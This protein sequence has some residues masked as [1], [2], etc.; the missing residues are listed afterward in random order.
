VSVRAAVGGGVVSRLDNLRAMRDFIDREIAT[1][2]GPL[3]MVGR[4]SGL[5]RDVADLYG[6]TVAEMLAG[7]RRHQVCRA[8]QGVAWLL[9]RGGMS[10]RDIARTLG[11]TDHS[12]AYHAIR[13]INADSATKALLI[14][15]EDAS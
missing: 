7:N 11:Y 5:V 13:K 2:L 15:L 12:T 14:G 4:D 1:E 8:R 10:H 3:L 9:K 6:V